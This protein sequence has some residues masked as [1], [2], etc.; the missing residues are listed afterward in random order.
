MR[1]IF[2]HTQSA[3]E[4]QRVAAL[5]LLLA[6]ASYTAAAP[7][8]PLPFLRSCSHLC[9]CCF[10]SLSFSFQQ[11]LTFCWND[12]RKLYI[13][14]V[15]AAFLAMNLNLNANLEHSL[16]SIPPRPSLPT[17]LQRPIILSS[18]RQRRIIIE[19]FQKSLHCY[20]GA[21]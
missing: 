6:A 8:L 16:S 21:I 13:L 18:K 7:V 20:Q 15:C 17:P 14:C 10:C 19:M 5:L 3:C 2:T 11:I 9:L 12:K 4:G 1:L